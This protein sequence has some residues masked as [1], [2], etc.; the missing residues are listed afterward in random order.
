MEATEIIKNLIDE[1]KI[2]G[3]QAIALLSAIQQK[4]ELNTQPNDKTNDK[5]DTKPNTK[6]DT[7]SNNDNDYVP[8]VPHINTSPCDTCP[9]IKT[10]PFYPYNPIPIIY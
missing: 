10:K 8:F 1:G 5:T 6:P 4:K 7:K 3:E 9:L 2:N